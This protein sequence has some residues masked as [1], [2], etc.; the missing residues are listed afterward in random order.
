MRAHVRERFMAEFFISSNKYSLSERQTKRGK[1]YDIRFRIVTP[2]GIEKQKRLAGYANKT[3]AKQAYIDFITEKCELI[4]NNPIIRQKKAEKGQ[5]IL[6]IKDLVNT[7]LKSIRNQI[8]DA[9]IYEKEKIFDLI[10][11]PRFGDCQLKH[12]TRQELYLWQDELWSNK[13]PKTND[14]YSYK[15]L[16]KIRSRTGHTFKKMI[17]AYENG[18]K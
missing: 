17:E 13:N 7:Y 12:L 2:D 4:K 6:A 16:S 14:Y 1:V 15:Y 18:I 10:I 5:E 8:K 9:T 11:L 3:L